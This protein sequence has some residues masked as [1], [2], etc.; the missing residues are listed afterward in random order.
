M[1]QK[2]ALRCVRYDLSRE[3][4]SL[5][6]ISAKFV[7]L[8]SPRNSDEM[9]EAFK[10]IEKYLAGEV[11]LVKATEKPRCFYC[12]TLNEETYGTCAQCGAPL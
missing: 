5:T 12:G 10:K 7:L 2:I 1:A 9:A 11:N 8:I 6:E 4:G 3:A